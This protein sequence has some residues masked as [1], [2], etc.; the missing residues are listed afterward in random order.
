MCG[1]GIQQV[2]QSY[3]TLYADWGR[4]T[5]NQETTTFIIDFIV[6]GVVLLIIWLC[7]RLRF[8]HRDSEV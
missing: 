5:M 6:G 4:D 2:A 8:R 7:P 1:A 3:G